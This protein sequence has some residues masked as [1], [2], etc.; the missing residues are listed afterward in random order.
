MFVE[1]LARVRC[2]ILES[3]DEAIEEDC[4]QGTENWANP[5]DPVVAGKDMKNDAGSER[6]SG[7]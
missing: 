1:I 4:E 6:S 2:S 5:I 3:F 7:I